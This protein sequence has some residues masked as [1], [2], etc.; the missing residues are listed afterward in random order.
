MRDI[1]IKIKLIIL[2]TETEFLLRKLSDKNGKM[3]FFE[4]SYQTENKICNIFKVISHHHN[5]VG[6][7]SFLRNISCG[8][9]VVA[10]CSDAPYITVF[11][12]VYACT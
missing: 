10:H 8:I 11:R 1:Q 6:K 5:S 9:A 4:T 2:P 12:S 3:F 7:P